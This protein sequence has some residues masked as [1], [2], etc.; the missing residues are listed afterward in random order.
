MAEAAG[1]TLAVFSAFNDAIQCFDYVHLARKFDRDSQSVILKLDITKL[2]LSRWGRALGFDTID[3]DGVKLPFSATP[4][5]LSK[6]SQ[7]LEHIQGLFSEAERVSADLQQENTTVMMSSEDAHLVGG[8]ESLH[9]VLDRLSR[10]NYHPKK[11]LKKAKWA[12]YSEKH[13]RRLFEDVTEE[14]DRLIE[15]FP[16]SQVAQR[17]LCTEEG[18]ELALNENV[19]LL[20]P[21]VIE[22]DPVLSEVIKEGK[23]AAFSSHHTSFNNSTNYGSQ[24]GSNSGTQ[25]FNFGDRK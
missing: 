10:K 6:A 9:E 4:E 20:E 15:L 17:Q 2:K 5:E 23:Q 8:I 18:K 16:A 12:L 22:H 21:L 3:V 1:L 13:V 19:G 11:M 25:T 7:L 14:V 24:Q